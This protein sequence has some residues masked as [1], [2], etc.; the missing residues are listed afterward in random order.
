M[1]DDEFLSQQREHLPIKH[2]ANKSPS[3]AILFSTLWKERPDS[4]SAVEQHGGYGGLPVI[5][6]GP[7]GLI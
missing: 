7:I 4:G 5:K 2:A 6:L 1:Y 3:P